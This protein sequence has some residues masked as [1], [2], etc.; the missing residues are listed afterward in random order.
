[1]TVMRIV[2]LCDFGEDGDAEYRMHAPSRMLGSLPGV[3][4][5]DCHFAYRRS[6]DLAM[7]ADIVVVQFH[8][9]WDVLSLVAE[10]RRRGRPTVF[11]AND[12]FFDLQPW[13]P[14]RQWWADRTVQELYSRLLWSAD[15]VQTSSAE[16]AAQWRRR[17]ARDV[18]VFAN[19][20]VAVEPLPE[21][22]SR[23][24]TIGWAGSPGHFADWWAVAPAVQR[25]LAAHPDT[26]L[27]VMC[28]G[29][30]RD[31]LPLPPERYHFTEFGTLP[32]YLAFL[33]RLDVGLAPLLPTDYNRG[34]SDVKF[35]EYASAGVVGVYSDLAPYR[36]S[37]LDG[38]T[39]LLCRTTDDLMGALDRL[40]ADTEQRLQ[41]RANAHE[42]VTRNR[43][44]ADHI[45]ERVQWYESLLEEARRRT[46]RGTD[47]G[48]AGAAATPDLEFAD[49]YTEVRAG[50]AEDRLR[51][52]T[53][54]SATTTAD[55][56]SAGTATSAA[57]GLAAL[58][59]LV[60]QDP[61]FVAAR[62]RLGLLLNDAGR[63]RDALEVLEAARA[64]APESGRTRMEIGRAHLLLQNG[65]A[66]KQDLLRV[67]EDVP[68]FVPGWQY[69]LR[70]LRIIRDPESA[71]WAERALDTFPTCY[72][73]GLTAIESFG[74][75]DAALHL[76]GLID[77]VAPGLTMLERPTALTAI[78]GAMGTV[79][80]AHPDAFPALAL[81]ASAAAGFP[82]SVLIAGWHGDVLRQTGRLRE[83][84][85]ELARAGNLRRAAEAVADE[86][87]DGEQTPWAWSFASVAES[88]ALADVVDA[89]GGPSPTPPTTA[90]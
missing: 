49:G 54:A 87:Q 24:F 23:P 68:G 50:A 11:E 53:E 51:H 70:L 14:L 66:A 36:D 25:W 71:L 84:T 1:M 31:F 60:D 58:T 81:L 69:L 77:R 34:R 65:Q 43:L 83:A 56:A 52:L 79:L 28:N 45:G 40:H 26:H 90:A 41:I 47:R 9:D 73:L 42:W 21:P 67:I 5:A 4:V 13:S 76:A 32:E 59:A 20:L 82:E 57:D 27:A 3:S 85:A 19:Q 17:G 18:A 35:L 10:R 8:N 12:Y 38:H 15:G 33:R 61:G 78:R 29:L 86:F 75:N 72:P 30:A 80:S 2:Q 46:R 89:D 7:D 22:V 63:P 55:A 44:L 16:L 62:Q 88:S 74:V 37:V 64:L 39:G 48:A 6:R